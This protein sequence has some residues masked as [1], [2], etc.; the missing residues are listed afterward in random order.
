MKIAIFSGS[1]DPIHE[2]HISLIKKANKLFDLLYI[3]V[4][5]NPDK[6]YKYSLNERIN[7]VKKKLLLEGLDNPILK[8]DGLTIDIAHSVGATYMIRGIRNSNDLS[9]EI[10]LARQ[11]QL[12]DNKIETIIFMSDLDKLDVSSSEIKKK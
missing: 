2:G 6:V 1:F 9:Y 4:S 12:L 8:N 11:N 5:I 10:E 3:V 7:L